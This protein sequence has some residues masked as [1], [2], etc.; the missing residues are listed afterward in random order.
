M[1]FRKIYVVGL[2]NIPKKEPIILCGNHS[3]QFIDAFMVLAFTNRKVCFTMANSSFT[4]PI[5]GQ[6]AKLIET[7]PVMRQEDFKIK[8]I[9]K[10]AFINQTEIKGLNSRFRSQTSD[11]NF[12]T[13]FIVVNKEIYSIK[14]I[15]DETSII[16]CSESLG[17]KAIPNFNL[18]SYYDYEVRILELLNSF[19]Q[20]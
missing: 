2:E 18:S 1:Y 20:K 12:E 10:L 15:V 6:C 7:I 5:V 16:L 3:N 4:K 17:T 8:G 14:E 13:W 11:T 9:G 19:S